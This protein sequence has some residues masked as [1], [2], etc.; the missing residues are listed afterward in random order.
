MTKLMEWLLF[1]VL[2]LSFWVSLVTKKIR[3]QLLD[4]YPNVVL[5]LPVI[6]VGIFGVSKFF[7]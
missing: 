1:G 3:H 7:M 2:F 4:D 5:F 6:S